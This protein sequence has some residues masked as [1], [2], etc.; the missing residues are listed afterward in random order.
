MRLSVCLSVCHTMT[1]EIPDLEKFILVCTVGLHPNVNFTRTILSSHVHQN[2]RIKRLLFAKN[3]Q[4]NI[5]IVKISCFFVSSCSRFR[6]T[7]E[8]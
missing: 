6:D 3:L 8:S 7:R 1:F 2:S 4:N 5:I